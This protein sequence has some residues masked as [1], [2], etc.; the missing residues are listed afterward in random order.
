LIVLS[1]ALNGGGVILR[2]APVSIANTLFAVQDNPGTTAFFNVAPTSGGS[3]HVGDLTGM[4]GQFSCGSFVARRNGNAVAIAALD[5]AGGK[6]DVRLLGSG[7][8]AAGSVQFGDGTGA[9]DI[10]LTRA[11][12]ALQFG[13][14]NTTRWTLAAASANLTAESAATITTSAG[15]MT[16]DSAAATTLGLGTGGASTL[17]SVGSAS[18]L[19]NFNYATIATGAGG[20]ATLGQVGASGPATNAQNSWLKVQVNGTNSF[21]PLWR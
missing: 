6:T 21:I 13:T 1:S 8:G 19:V 10:F 16:I 9:L 5:G 3:V 17:V 11:A 14:T 18:A 4:D 7:A 20:A 2:D 12:G 15:A